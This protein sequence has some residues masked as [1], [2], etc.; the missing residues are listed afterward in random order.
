MEGAFVSAVMKVPTVLLTIATNNT[1]G[2]TFSYRQR[3]HC[4]GDASIAI[5]CLRPVKGSHYV[6]P[7]GR[8]NGSSRR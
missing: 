4:L 5:C 1:V 6:V 8:M 2:D 3:D 7:I